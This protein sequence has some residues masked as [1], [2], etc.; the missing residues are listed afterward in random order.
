M[1]TLSLQVGTTPPLQVE[2]EDQFP[3]PLETINAAL[4]GVDINKNKK[5]MV[6]LLTK[7]CMVKNLTQAEQEKS[8][9]LK[10]RRMT[11]GLWMPIA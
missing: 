3:L 10:I 8:F 9:G 2:V 7:P 6:M 4:E 1:T 11:V 5:T